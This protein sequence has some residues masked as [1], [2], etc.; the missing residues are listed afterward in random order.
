[1][2]GVPEE[3]EM[4]TEVEGEAW[5]MGHVVVKISNPGSPWE[6]LVVG[7]SGR[8]QE[9]IAGVHPV[10]TLMM[11]EM[12]VKERDQASHSKT[13]LH[14][15]RRVAGGEVVQRREVGGEILAK[16]KLT[17]MIVVTVK[18]VAVTAWLETA[19]MTVNKELHQENFLMREVLGVVEGM[20]S[21]RS[22]TEPND[23]E[24]GRGNVTVMLMEKRGGALTKTTL[25]APRTKQMMMAGPLSVAE[26]TACASYLPG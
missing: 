5:M 8:R 3:A 24:S 25:V 21:A 20:I 14:K 22:R 2:T 19:E 9:R 6:D 7:G 15:K 17:V 10:V 13:V 18:T 12:M 16:R 23:P 26:P 11:K 1:M 4:M